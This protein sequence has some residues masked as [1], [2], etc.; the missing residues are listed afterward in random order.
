M[1]SSKDIKEKIENI[2]IEEDED[3]SDLSN[4]ADDSMDDTSDSDDS[5]TD[6]N[7]DNNDNKMDSNENNIEDFEQKLKEIEA[8][9]EENKFNYQS[10]LDIINLL[11]SSNKNNDEKLKKC[12]QTMSEL[13]PL[14]ESNF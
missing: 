7:D 13:F 14:T 3:E 9:I 12:R 10:H 5:Q 1:E 6:D 4:S 2:S 8:S 11:K